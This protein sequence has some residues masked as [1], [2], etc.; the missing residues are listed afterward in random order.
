MEGIAEFRIVDDVYDVDG[1]TR[2]VIDR[3]RSVSY[4]FNGFFYR[5]AF[6]GDLKKYPKVLHD[7]LL[8]LGRCA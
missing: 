1:V 6:F 3:D 5:V 7:V 8:F 2:Q 4:Q